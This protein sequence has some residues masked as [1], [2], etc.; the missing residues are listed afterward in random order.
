MIIEYTN[1]DHIVHNRF[2]FIG[3]VYFLVL[4]KIK[5]FNRYPVPPLLEEQSVKLIGGVDLYSPCYF[6]WARVVSSTK[7]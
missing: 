6:T 4:Q 5:L 7:N 2:K 3:Y 1:I